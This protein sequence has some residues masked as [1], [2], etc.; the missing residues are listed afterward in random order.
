MALTARQER[1]VEEYMIDLDAKN[2]AIRAGYSARSAKTLGP[3]LTKMKN[4]AARIEEE[5]AKRAR[6]T[7][8]TAERVLRELAQLAFFDASK[9]LGMLNGDMEKMEDF[10]ASKCLGMLNGDMEKMEELERETASIAAIK[11]GKGG[12]E[13]RFHDKTRALELL[14][15]HMGIFREENAGREAIQ[16]ELGSGVEE[17]AE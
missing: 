13:I 14:G 5:K 12:I 7:G 2:A 1:F 10:D 16:V 15:R 9:C 8:I 11:I 3:R 4:V 17:L 6:R